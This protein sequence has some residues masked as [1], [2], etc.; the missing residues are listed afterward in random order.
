MLFWFLN[1][2]PNRIHLIPLLKMHLH[3]VTYFILLQKYLMCNFTWTRFFSGWRILIKGINEIKQYI[4]FYHFLPYNAVHGAHDQVVINIR[5]VTQRSLVRAPQ[6]LLVVYWTLR[7]GSLSTLS[8][9]TQLNYIL[10]YAGGFII[11]TMETEGKH[12]L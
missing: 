1:D 7:Q 8:R 10:A 2:N 6:W 9:S 5:P 12:Q 3:D 11:S 4:C